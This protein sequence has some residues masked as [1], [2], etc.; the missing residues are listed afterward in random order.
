MAEKLDY[1]IQIDEQQYDVTAADSLHAD[2]ANQVEEALIVKKS[3]RKSRNYKAPGSDTE[4]KD[5]ESLTIRDLKAAIGDPSTAI[6]VDENGDTIDRTATNAFAFKGDSE[7]EIEVVPSSGGVFTG[8]IYAPDVDAGDGFNINKFQVTNYNSV[9]TIVRE[10]KGFPVYEW[11]GTQVLALTESNPPKML[12]FK[13]IIYTGSESD[14][15]ANRANLELINVL[16]DG[17]EQECTTKGKFFLINATDDSEN[18]G[19]ILLGTYTPNGNPLCTYEE[20]RVKE[21]DN[22]DTLGATNGIGSVIL[23]IYLAKGDDG[24]VATACYERAGGTA[25]TLN[26]SKKFIDDE[27]T[28]ETLTVAS[29]YAPSGGG[30][31]PAA[32]TETDA[33][34][35]ADVLLSAG[36]GEAPTWGKQNSLSVKEAKNVTQKIGGKSLSSIFVYEDDDNNDKTPKVMTTQVKSAAAAD[37]VT[38]KIGGKSLSSIFVYADTDDDPETPN[39]ITPKVKSAA[40]ADSATNATN[41]TNA[42]KIYTYSVGGSSTEAYFSAGYA[43]Y[44]LYGEND[45]PTNK[46]TSATGMPDAKNLFNEGNIYIKIE[47]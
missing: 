13:V 1:T 4:L 2:L 34:V 29:F 44:I 5:I 11:T 26:G 3:V 46:G 16:P 8:P 45:V 9:D 37:N 30:T 15:W 17:T 7:A 41:A 47:P 42:E 27:A 19:R 28:T 10:L 18:G 25:V 43:G 23:P 39:V 21:A 6:G 33:E 36:A 32:A 35:L 14:G 20:L 38:Q 24:G 12:P 22:A 40:Q 31:A